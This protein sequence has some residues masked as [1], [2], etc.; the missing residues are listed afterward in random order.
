L[1]DPTT[2]LSPALTA[3]AQAAERLKQ[4]GA[5]GEAPAAS[6]GGLLEK[7][8][9]DAVDAGRKSEAAATQAVLG[10]ASLQD[11]V[12]AVNAAEITLQTVVA[13]RDRMINAYQEIIRM[14][15]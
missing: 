1:P 10:Q 4:P 5:S 3:Y 14:P 6:F 8:L 15:I 12:E 9:G 13:V 7:V 11:V 2:S